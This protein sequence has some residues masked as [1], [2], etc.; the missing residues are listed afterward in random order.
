MLRKSW[1]ITKVTSSDGWSVEIGDRGT[2]VYKEKKVRVWVGIEIQ[3][4]GHPW[5]VYS[6]DM[7]VGSIQGAQLT[8]EKLRSLILERIKAFFDFI[9][10]KY[11]IR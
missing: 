7:R 10:Y 8:D 9:K 2:V 3:G 11:E 6:G 4:R 1:F 5:V